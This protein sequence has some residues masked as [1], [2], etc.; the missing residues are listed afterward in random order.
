MNGLPPVGKVDRELFEKTI[1]NK[2]GAKNKKVLI[3]PEHGVDASAIKINKNKAMVISE[4]PTFS[5]P[6]IQNQFG[7]AVV[8]ICASDVAVLGVDPELMTI[9]LL[10]PP[11]TED[12]QF[13]QIWNQIHTECKKHNITIVG[14]HTGVYPGIPAP[15]NGGGTVIGYGNPKDLTP[16]SNAQTGD[17]IIMT[18]GP[19]I[20][21]TGILAHKSEKQL[22][23]KYNTKLIEKAKKRYHDMT[24]LKDAAIA[25]K[26]SNAM[27]DATEGG[28]INGIHEITQASKKGCKIHKNKI[29][30]PPE[31]K[32]VCNHHNINPLTSISE[33]TLLL[34]CPPKNTNK[35]QKNLKKNNIQSWIIGEITPQKNG[36]KIINKNGQEKQL[37]PVKTDPFWKTFF[38]KQPEK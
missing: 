31:I 26:H 14:G 8:H 30:I 11:E 37:K 36:T 4:D 16:P 2:L 15:L 3:G 25:R 17:K 9:C 5:M 21:A 24:V 34:T 12:S 28:I 35:I 1:Y 19:A 22:K 29:P 6:S 38:K 27:H 18:K 13:Q 10:L 7:W 20:E 32:A 23:T 33:G